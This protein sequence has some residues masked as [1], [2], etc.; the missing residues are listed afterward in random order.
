MKK[1]TIILTFLLFFCNTYGQTYINKQWVENYGSPDAIPWSATFADIW[2]NI[3]TIGNTNVFGQRA[4]ILITRFDNQGS[5]IWQKD[6]NGPLNGSDYGVDL[7]GDDNLGYIYATGASNYSNDTTFDITLSKYDA[8]GNLIW[9]TNYDK[10]GKNDYPVKMTMDEN[11]YLYIVGSCESLTNSFD[12]VTLKFDTSGTLIWDAHYDYNQHIDV[13]SNIISDD[14]GTV[15]T[16]TGGSEDSI[17]IWDYTTI[18]Y[19]VYGNQTDVQRTPATGSDI[20]K[21]RDIVKD[22]NGSYY[23]TCNYNNGFNKDIK[24]IKLDSTLNPVWVSVFD[25]GLDEGSNALTIDELGYLY[26]GGWQQNGPDLRVFL[27]IKYDQSGNLIWQQ[28]LLPDENKPFSEITG[29]KINSGAINLIG[30]CSYGSNSD[31][32]TA[33][34]GIDNGALE[35]IEIWEHSLSSIDYPTDIVQD[36]SDIYVTGRTEDNY[37][38]HWVIIKYSK[39]KRDTSI[40]RDTLG[41]P[42]FFKNHLIVRFDH[43]VVKSEVI[44]GSQYSKT[45]FG[46]LN[47]FLKDSAA[48]AVQNKLEKFSF[49]SNYKLLKIFTELRTIDTIA[50]SRLGEPIP[51]PKFWSTFLLEFP[52]GNNLNEVADSLDVLF[53]LVKYVHP[54]FIFQKG[55]G[56]NDSLYNEQA[57][58]HPANSYDSAHINVEPAWLITEAKQYIKVGVFDDGV[59]WKHKDFGYTGSPSSSII[60]DGWDLETKADLKSGNGEGNHGTPVASIIGA[61]K[62]NSI[63]IA[64]IAGRNNTISNTGVSLYCMR[65][66]YQSSAMSDVTQAITETAMPGPGLHRYGLNISN[67]SWWRNSLDDQVHLTDTN[68]TLLREAIHFVNRLKVTFVA[69]SGNRPDVEVIPANIDSNWILCVGGT[70]IDGGYKYQTNGDNNFEPT[71]GKQVDISAPCTSQLIRTLDD[72]GNC[73]SFWGT[74]AAAPHVTGVAALLLSYLNDSFASYRNLAPEDVE[75]ILEMSATDT[76]TVGYDILTGYGRLNAGSALELVKK[77]NRKLLHYSTDSNTN[78]KVKTLLISNKRISIG[79][80]YQNAESTPVWF[81]PGEY[82]VDVYKIDVNVN[83]TFGSKYVIMA[84]WPRHSSSDLLP[85][86]VG[87]KLVPRERILLNYAN[88]NTA[89]LTGY[90]YKVKD[91]LNNFVGWWPFDTARNKSHFSYTL[92]LRDSTIA[93][94]QQIDKKVNNILIYPNPSGN[95]QSILIKVSNHQKLDIKLYD[96]CGRMINYVFSGEIGPGEQLFN[97]DLS[98]ICSGIY[99][100]KINIGN[101]QVQSKIIIP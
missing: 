36:G 74:S 4:N 5:I 10:A 82:N 72:N 80:R 88:R 64:G 33:S 35:W 20:K 28:T 77:S 63:G 57:S 17:G 86:F 59:A 26:I 76:D 46:T 30:F 87:K 75:H 9:E 83:H 93:N 85:L 44:N 68:Y 3:N 71:F 81:K 54:D 66:L 90:I 48:E 37:G 24:L 2:G 14:Y 84:K 50:I 65:I 22:A 15:I 55:A 89:S 53:P 51:V 34:L 69:I 42:L 19:D 60:V 41:N 27:T 95:Q 16:V 97:V 38:V 92:L 45:E 73:Q 32:V 99:I 101:S 8:S 31:I 12:I 25:G 62:N 91:T 70:G 58:L 43:K 78:S 47:D 29:L 67:N 21:P 98:K 100:Y 13:A 39:F 79:E 18:T 94:I 1:L 49:E 6:W 61:I 52:D 23:I 40:T 11:G 56:P 7:I 96:I